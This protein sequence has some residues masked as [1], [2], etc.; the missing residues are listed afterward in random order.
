MR[1]TI[2]LEKD[3]ASRMVRLSSEG[4]T[5]RALASGHSQ[6]QLRRLLLE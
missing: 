2:T 6:G 4:K 3:V 5:D 1:T